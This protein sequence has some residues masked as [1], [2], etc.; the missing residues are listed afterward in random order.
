MDDGLGVWAGGTGEVICRG[1]K[2]LKEGTIQWAEP[3]CVVRVIVP[4]I[5]IWL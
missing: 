2:D 1:G 5:S 4:D 3:H